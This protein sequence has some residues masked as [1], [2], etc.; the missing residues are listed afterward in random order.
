MHVSKYIVSS[1]VLGFT[2]L[3]MKL[4]LHAEYSVCFSYHMAI[5]PHSPQKDWL[6]AGHVIA[7]NTSKSQGQVLTRL[8]QVV[9]T[10]GL[11]AAVKPTP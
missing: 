6:T 5:S 3:K 8:Y 9:P 11:R 7:K 10:T 4:L 1:F 2:C